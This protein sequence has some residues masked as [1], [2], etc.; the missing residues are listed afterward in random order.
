MARQRTAVGRVDGR[1]D[2][3]DDG[4]RRRRPCGAAAPVLRG[5]AAQ[6]RGGRVGRVS[7]VVGPA[8]HARARRHV[9]A[10]VKPEWRRGVATQLMRSICNHCSIGCQRGV[11]LC[12]SDEARRVYERL[13]FGA[14]CCC[15]TCRRRAS[16]PATWSPCGEL[17]GA[18]ADGDLLGTGGC[19]AAGGVSASECRTPRGERRS[20]H[21]PRPRQARVPVVCHRSDGAVVGAC[22]QVEAP[23]EQR[24]VAEAHQD[25]RRLEPLRGA[26]VPRARRGGEAARASSAGG[27]R[28]AARRASRPRFD[29]DAAVLARLGF[30][31]QN[32]MVVELGR[33]SSPCSPIDLRRR[34]GAA[35]RGDARDGDVARGRLADPRGAVVQRRF[36]SPAPSSP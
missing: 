31:P 18:D 5:R 21:R 27:R 3:E 24:I 25:W 15:T 19:A 28:Q 1:P 29:D 13:G 22:C 17:A 8:R 4:V 14:T 26:R 16:R 30:T 32:A 35:A 23:A 33:A 36:A 12:A 34:G 11:L 2:G 20:V 7:A 6:R 9:G 10:F